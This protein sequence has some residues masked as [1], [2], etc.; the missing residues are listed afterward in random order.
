MDPKK[1]ADILNWKAP[2]DVRGIKS[3]IGMAG[4][5]RRF[6]EDFPKIARTMI[7]LLANKI[8]FKWTQKC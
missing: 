6:I 5:Y 4:Y 2:K 8:D 3:F 1:V 7:V